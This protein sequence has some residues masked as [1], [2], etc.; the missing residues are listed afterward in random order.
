MAVLAPFVDAVGGS[1]VRSRRRTGGP[2]AV[3]FPE[4]EYDQMQVERI[5][6]SLED[7]SVPSAASDI[8][9]LMRSLLQ[10]AGNRILATRHQTT[11]LPASSCNRA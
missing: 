5:L 3:L 2:S 9:E 11:T 8:E 1:Q 7:G 4:D 10:A 6:K